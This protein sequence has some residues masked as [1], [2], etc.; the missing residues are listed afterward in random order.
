MR[1]HPL[2]KSGEK[3][4]FQ[5]QVACQA[6]GPFERRLREVGAKGLFRGRQLGGLCKNSARPNSYIE[7]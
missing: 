4:P 6:L 3:L 2:E 5:E 1:E 7:A